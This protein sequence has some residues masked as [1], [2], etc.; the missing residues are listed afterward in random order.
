[1]VK[2]SSATCWAKRWAAT[3]QYDLWKREIS[4]FKY[5]KHKIVTTNHELNSKDI[6]FQLSVYRK[7][8]FLSKTLSWKQQAHFF[9]SFFS[10]KINGRQRTPTRRQVVAVNLYPRRHG[11]IND[12]SVNPQAHLVRSALSFP[13]VTVKWCA[14]VT[15]TTMDPSPIF[16]QNYKTQNSCDFLFFFNW[17]SW[18]G[19][20]SFKGFFHNPKLEITRCYQVTQSEWIDALPRNL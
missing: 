9:F 19:P 10:Q 20:W 18:C 11:Q 6:L 12:V 5:L 15:W 1:M 16:T 2:C 8:T 4:L 14:D 17:N 13:D 7:S 3:S